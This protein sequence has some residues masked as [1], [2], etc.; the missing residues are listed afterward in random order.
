MKLDKG[1]SGLDNFSDAL[2]SWYDI[3]ARSLPWRVPPTESKRGVRGNPYHI[4]LSEVMLQQ[5][6][7]ATVKAYFEKFIGIWPSVEAMAD[8]SQEEVLAQWAGLGYYSRARNLKT[9]AD[10]VVA[11]YGG[12]FP[13]TREALRALPGIGD[14]T[15]AAIATIAFGQRE[16]V[17]DGNIERVSLRQLADATP[18]PA[19]KEVARNFMEQHTPQARP[20]DFVQAMMDLGATICRPKNPVCGLCPVREN[21]TASKAGT[22]LDFPV[23]PQKKTK[24]TRRGAAFFLED[25]K[26]S[27]W[28]MRREGK[29]LLG[30]MAALPSTNWSSRADGAVGDTAAPDMV[31]KTVWQQAGTV[32]HTFTHFHLELEVWCGEG[33]PASNEGWW[34]PL[35]G[36]KEAGLPTVFAKAV[37]LA[38]E[39]DE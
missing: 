22:M 16:A 25:G 26:G 34:H 29:G 23:K 21:C 18:L 37:A 7:V 11:E 4:W 38:L 27:V 36:L 1:A 28:L 3:H 19:A 5:T 24:P 9:C 2:L 35:S 32:R 12:Q 30:G 31:G 33:Q 20:G 10:I 13:Q 15:S 14:Y 8:A 39:H 6:T 17:V